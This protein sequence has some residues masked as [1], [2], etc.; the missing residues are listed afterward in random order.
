MTIDVEEFD[1]DIAREGNSRRIYVVVLPLARFFLIGAACVGVAAAGFG[2][3]W[4]SVGTEGI[5]ALFEPKP[6]DETGEVA[7]DLPEMIVNLS[8]D[9][10]VRFLKIGLTVTLDSADKGAIENAM[11]RLI[12]AGQDFLRNLDR[13]D[14]KGS[15]GLARLRLEFRRRVN[16]TLGREAVREVLLRS[17]LIQ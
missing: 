1:V 12:D 14:L 6:N 16:L 10:A 8:G 2:G 7:V 13:H 9:G 17:F 3:Y 11:P 5:L 4:A 15:A